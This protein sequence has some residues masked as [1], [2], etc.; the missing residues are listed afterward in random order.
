MKGL[1]R[2]NV[3]TTI[4]IKKNYDN[5]LVIQIYVDDIIFRSTNEA[6]CQDFAKLI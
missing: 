5:I 6:L 4:F 1:V 2:R 3:D